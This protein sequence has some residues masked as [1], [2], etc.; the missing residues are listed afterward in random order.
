M[1]NKFAYALV[2]GALVAPLPFAS[3]AEAGWGGCGYRPGLFTSAIRPATC[4]YQGDYMVQQWASHDGPARIA[5]QDVYA[6][7]RS[8]ANYVHG[9]YRAAPAVEVEPTYRRTVMRKGAKVSVKSDLP[10]KGKVQIVNARAEVRIYGS[11]RMEIKLYR[12]R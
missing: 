8:V 7:S 5:P 11:E 10:K 4:A 12:A 1:K 3:P 6:P 9:P 2:A